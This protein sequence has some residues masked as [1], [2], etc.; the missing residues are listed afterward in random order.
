M[1]GRILIVSRSIEERREGRTDGC[2]YP[3]VP[4]RRLYALGS[5]RGSSC[6]SFVDCLGALRERNTGSYYAKRV[7]WRELC[8]SE[9]EREEERPRGGKMK[10][11]IGSADG[12]R[13]RERDVLRK[14]KKERDVCPKKTERKDRDPRER[15]K[16]VPFLRNA[17]RLER[18]VLGSS[19]SLP[20]DTTY[21]VLSFPARGV[22]ESSFQRVQ[23]QDGGEGK[24]RAESMAISDVDGGTRE[25][26]IQ[27]G[28]RHSNCN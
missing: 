24:R 27:E 9:K 5:P 6:V 8:E 26:R 13:Y 15:R 17:F 7:S 23:G 12:G 3:L 22:P 20:I 25:S 2:I 19:L 14:E 16:P 4:A 21:Y 10:K 18:T 11:R 28:R 1:T